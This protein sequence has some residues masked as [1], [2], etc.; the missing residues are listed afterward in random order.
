MDDLDRFF[1]YLVRHLAHT[2]P[3]RL[4][5]PMQISELYQRVLPYRFHRSE[6][7]FESVEDY[8]LALLRLLAGEQGYAAV[9]PADVQQ[10]FIEELDS[11]NPNTGAYRDYAAATVILAPSA[12][13]AVLEEHAQ[14]APPR[15]EAERGEDLEGSAGTEEAPA[16]RPAVRFI[17]EQEAPPSEPEAGRCPGCAGTLPTGRMVAYCPFCG[18]RLAQVPCPAC[19]AKVE[20]G[21]RFCIACGHEVPGSA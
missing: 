12:I 4:R 17:L 16:P 2:D 21:W 19:S 8:E 11:M 10:V 14:Y 7:G 9:T 1:R 20:L 13:T 3:E 6:L 15:E 5:R 18:R